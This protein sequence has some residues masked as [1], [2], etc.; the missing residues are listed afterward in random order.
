MNQNALQVALDKQ[1]NVNE[2]HHRHLED[3]NATGTEEVC[4]ET[5]NKVRSDVLHRL[6]S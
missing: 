1:T 5:A 6:V 3:E 4:T 2:F